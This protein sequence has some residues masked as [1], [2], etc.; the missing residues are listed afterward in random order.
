MHAQL[1]QKEEIENYHL[2]PAE[3]DNTKKWKELLKYFERLGNQ[4]KGKCH[5]DFNTSEGIRA[6]ETTVWSVYEDRVQLK[7]SISLPLNAILE[8]H[9]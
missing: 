5:I 7:G 4:Y 6:V 9:H 1:I 3:Q 8:I 2:I